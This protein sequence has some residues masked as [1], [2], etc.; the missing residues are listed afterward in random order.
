MRSAEC[1]G[2][3]ERNSEPTRR[4]ESEHRIIQNSEFVLPLE[5][6]LTSQPLE[7]FLTLSRPHFFRLCSPAPLPLEQL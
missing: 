5:L 3:E 4:T 7:L 6:F 2:A 1:G